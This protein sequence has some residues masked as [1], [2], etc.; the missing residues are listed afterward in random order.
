MQG[1][2]GARGPE[3]LY[4]VNILVLIYIAHKNY[5]VLVLCSGSGSGMYLIAAFDPTAIF[6]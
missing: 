1:P 2:Q 5:H 3:Y 4:P 6:C